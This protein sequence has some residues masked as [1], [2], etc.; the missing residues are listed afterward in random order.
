VVQASTLKAGSC[1][2]ARGRVG[3]AE[4]GGVWEG[5]W[6]GLGWV[7]GAAVALLLV[8]LAE[9]AGIAVVDSAEGALTVP[10]LAGSA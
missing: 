3:L 4:P 5:A 2:G 10:A 6:L 1:D 9:G 8:A 7:V